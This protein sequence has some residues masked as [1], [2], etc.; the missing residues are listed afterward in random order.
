M[1]DHSASGRLA[2]G[3]G[4]GVYALVVQTGLG[5]IA[6]GV[7]DTLGST[8]GVRIAEVLGQAGAGAGA[9][10]LVADGV[11][12]A[13]RWI[14]RRS[15]L[16]G[17]RRVIVDSR[18]LAER[19]ARVAGVT[20]ADGIVLDDVA[21]GVDTAGA[22]TRVRALFVLAGEISRALLVDDALGSAVWRSA[23]VVRQAG[24][25]REAVDDATLRVWTAGRLDAGILRWSRRQYLRLVLDAAEERISGVAWR[26][27]ADWIV[28]YH[29]TIGVQ[30]ARA[31]ARI[32]A[33]LN[34]AGLVLGA[35]RADDAFGTAGRRTA[36]VIRL[37]S[38]DG[39]IVHHTTVAVRTARRWLAGILGT[40]GCCNRIH[41]H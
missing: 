1:I 36:D 7:S 38:A 6:V 16:L 15:R 26:A 23:D 41:S 10:S 40:S 22:W 3:S 2:A 8:A 14:A 25:G 24:A 29:L 5:A 35:V 19:I 11:G 37:A 33:A 34:D 4:A 17:R 30:A 39:V 18:A 32:L 27:A 28:I 31:D 20:V 21:E 9:V 13:R 12:S